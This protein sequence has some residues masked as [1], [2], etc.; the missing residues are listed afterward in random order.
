MSK[1]RKIILVVFA[2]FLL[3]VL[4]VVVTIFFVGQS[5]RHELSQ[6]YPPPGDMLPRGA[7]A[8]HVLCKG[9]GTPA[10]VLEAG[11][12]NFSLHWY[13]VQ[14]LL[15]RRYK[16]CAYDRAGL[17]WSGAS[18]D[19]P[20]IEQA[21]SDLHAVIEAQRDQQPV[22]MISHSYGALIARMYAQKHGKN[23]IAILMLDP[24]NERMPEKI[25]GY[26]QVIDANARQFETLYWLARMGLMALSLDD[27]PAMLLQGET[28]TQYRAALAHGTFFLG[29]AAESRA[30]LK[31]M[32]RVA[33]AKAEY[34]DTIP[35]TI[36]SRTQPEPIADLPEETNAHLEQIWAELQ[37]DL[38][39]RLHARQMKADQSGHNV[40]LQQPELVAQLAMEMLAN[41]FSK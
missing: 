17:G 9:K 21:V 2:A 14:D 28:L 30:V 41:T 1:P 35:I 7:Y 5:T 25:K 12:N 11:L 22:M 26:A 16:T 13:Q 39:H 38:V 23:L 24:A 32:Q 8:L 6:K 33:E 15:A 29:A 18:T 37:T 20:H 36:L 31:N 10:I 4:S 40:Q 27:I 3:F 34:I 19:A